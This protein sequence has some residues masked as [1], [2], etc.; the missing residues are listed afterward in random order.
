[1][2]RA[3]KRVKQRIMDN[4]KYMKKSNGINPELEPFLARRMKAQGTEL[5]ASYLSFISQPGNVAGII[6]TAVVATAK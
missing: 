3:I 2:D 1:V 6:E 5:K 4:D